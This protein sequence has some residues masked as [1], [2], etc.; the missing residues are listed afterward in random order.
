[1][2]QLISSLLP[3]QEYGLNWCL[4]REENGCILADDMGLGKTVTS[5]ALMVSNH[6][7]TIIIVPVALLEQ[8]DAEISKHTDG[9]STFIY[10]GDNRNKMAQESQESQESLDFQDYDIVI[11]TI[12]TIISDFKKGIIEIYKN[13]DRIIIDEA[14]KLKNYKSVSH[15]II[16]TVFRRT[17][18]KLLL[19]GTPICNNIGD[20]I[21]LIILL[22]MSPYNNLDYWRYMPIEE[23]ICLI[24]ENKNEFVLHRTKADILKSTLPDIKINTV[25]LSLTNN[26]QS[27]TYNNLKKKQH[28]FKLL[29]ILRMRQCLNE[30]KL[31]NDNDCTDTNEISNEI[32][33]VLCEKIIKVQSIIQQVPNNE[34]I[35]I[36]SQWK[37]MLDILSEFI[38]IPYVIYHG[39]MNMKEKNETLEK[40]KTCPDT[41]I[42][43]ITL[44][45]GGCGLNLNVANHA[46]IVEPY[47][48]HSEERQ[49]IDRIYRIGQTK[50]VFINKLCI[51]NSVEN[52]MR[53]LQSSKLCLSGMILQ[54]KGTSDDIEKNLMRTKKMFEF[55][56]DECGDENDEDLDI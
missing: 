33:D 51:S 11:T 31:I 37:T 23:K 24:E 41:R 19:T 45:C 6:V 21:S 54:N 48:N 16:S 38:D 46:I 30:I 53:Q 39:G 56:V 26:L 20:L 10:H 52:W 25:K 49:A 40:F 42:L 18:Y 7:K 17:Q 2:V 1:M 27:K 12:H 14:H 22:N 15:M 13:F 29:K 50:K 4:K 43:L 44:K 9:L 34:K 5:C 28:S 32:R 47:Y 3:H 36:F 55:F 35:V 8:W